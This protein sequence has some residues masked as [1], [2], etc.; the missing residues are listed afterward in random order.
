M[1]LIGQF[2]SPFVRRVALA[3]N[4]YGLR[5]EHRPWSVWAQAEEIAA[6]SPLRRVPVLV[7]EDGVALVES[8]AILDA[9]DEMVA[10]ERRLLPRS[11]RLRR[12]GLRVCALATGLADKVVSLF[13]E[14]A[15]RK[16]DGR[17]VVWTN[18]CRAQIADTLRVLESERAARSEPHWFATFSHADIAVGCA[19]RFLTEALPEVSWQAEYPAL[20]AHMERC[21][22]SALFQSAV[23]AFHVAL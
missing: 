14:A 17:S 16:E 12:D 7:M 5:Y 21:E 20:C 19:L 8:F 4:H 3:L 2:D 11:G 1:I 22:E 13:Y 10:E 6:Y 18:R 9:V 23:Q 15:L